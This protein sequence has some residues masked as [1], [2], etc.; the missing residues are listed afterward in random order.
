[1]KIKIIANAE[2]KAAAKSF[3]ARIRFYRGLLHLTQRELAD[4]VQ[5]RLKGADNAKG[6]AFSYLSKI[7][8]DKLPPPSMP[9]TLHIAAT[10]GLNP[11]ELDELLDLAG[12]PPVGLGEKL[13]QK[14]KARQF[15]RAAIDRLTE[16]EWGS[17]L[18]TLERKR[19]PML[20]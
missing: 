3:G 5:D 14:P 12:R 15:F 18:N 8:S 17:L 11:D 2:R 10:L 6:F 16:E 4:R 20:S 1:M 19:K 13:A 7:E 9:V